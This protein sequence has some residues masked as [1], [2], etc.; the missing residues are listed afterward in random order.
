MKKQKISFVNQ[1]K[2]VKVHLSTV[3]MVRQC[4]YKVLEVEGLLDI[5]HE[6]S[7]TF[8]CNAQIRRINREFRQVDRATDVLSFPV[9]EY[10]ENYCPIYGQGDMDLTE[11]GAVM[12]GDIVISLERCQEQAKEFGH[13]ARREIAYLT[14]HSMYHLL[15]YDHMEEEEKKQM[16]SKEEHVL[17]LMGITRK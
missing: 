1:Q 8:V 10:D 7:V 12:L 4:I 14:V 6:V 15:G 16:R 9:L 11:D 13:S 17:S 5:P 3:H 2:K